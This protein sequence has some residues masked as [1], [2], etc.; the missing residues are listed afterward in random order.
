M[1]RC[2]NCGHLEANNKCYHSKDCDREYSEWIPQERGIK[3]ED[4]LKL[5]CKLKNEKRWE[6]IV[7]E[8]AIQRV[9]NKL[10]KQINRLAKKV[11]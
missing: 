4:I 2:K 3:H 10:E 11:K 9:L 1:P 5:I 6:M 8:K 7:T